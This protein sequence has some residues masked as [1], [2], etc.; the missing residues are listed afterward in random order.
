M[1]HE[2]ITSSFGT[3]D[4]TTLRLALIY[5]TDNSLQWLSRP[6]MDQNLRAGQSKPTSPSADRHVVISH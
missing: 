3:A 6:R 5:S 1:S 4:L 2:A